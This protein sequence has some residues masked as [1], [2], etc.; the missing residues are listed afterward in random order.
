[1]L[2]VVLLSCRVVSSVFL[3]G[4]CPD[5][6]IV[7]WNHH[8][9]SYTDTTGDLDQ[10]KKKGLRCLIRNSNTLDYGSWKRERGRNGPCQN[11]QGFFYVYENIFFSKKIGSYF[12]A[13]GSGHYIVILKVFYYLDLFFYINNFFVAQLL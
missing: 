7:L 4:S 2:V 1:M 11:N 9:N 8:D 10:Q 6:F 5:V 13:E 12:L 3:Y